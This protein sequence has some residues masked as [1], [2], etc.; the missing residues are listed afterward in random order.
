MYVHEHGMAIYA[1][2]RAHHHANEA[3]KCLARALEF[4]GDT[5]TW[6]ATQAKSAQLIAAQWH[7]VAVDW[8]T[9]ADAL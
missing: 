5:H 7:Q 6:F 9:Q 2:R 1:Q 8:M 4:K 3:A